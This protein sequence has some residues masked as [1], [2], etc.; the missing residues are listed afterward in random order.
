MYAKRW[1][2]SCKGKNAFNSFHFCRGGIKA[3]PDGAEIT[4]WERRRRWWS[5]LLEEN[6]FVCPF[7]FINDFNQEKG[8]LSQKRN[9]SNVVN[10]WYGWLK[11]V[12]VNIYG[13][14]KINRF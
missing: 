5:F 13:F 2:I 8:T 14:Q 1:D 10:I 12:T 7:S 9:I 3:G 11:N 4:E 6:F